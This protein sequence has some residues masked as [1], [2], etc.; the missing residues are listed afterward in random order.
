MFYCVKSFKFPKRENGQERDKNTY[1]I[2]NEI[3]SAVFD[4]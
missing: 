2:V 3:F 4:I 1:L